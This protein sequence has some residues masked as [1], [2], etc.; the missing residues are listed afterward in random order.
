[1]RK[2]QTHGKLGDEIEQDGAKM[3]REKGGGLQESRKRAQK[4]PKE[5]QESPEMRPR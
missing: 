4:D 2:W 1:M 3:R 5:A